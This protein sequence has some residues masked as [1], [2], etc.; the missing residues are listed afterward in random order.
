MNVANTPK[1]PSPSDGHRG[2]RPLV[3]LRRPRIGRCLRRDALRMHPVGF[4]RRVLMRLRPIR[5]LRILE[6]QHVVVLS[7][8]VARKLR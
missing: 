1:G 5:A 8:N 7:S 4:I 3:V 6:A 2:Q